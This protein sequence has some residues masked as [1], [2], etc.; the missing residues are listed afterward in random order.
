MKPKFEK[1][2]HALTPMD[3]KDGKDV[4]QQKVR[5][6]VVAFALIVKRGMR[7]SVLRA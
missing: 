6:F 4:I 1:F 7:K 3:G 5:S 2:K